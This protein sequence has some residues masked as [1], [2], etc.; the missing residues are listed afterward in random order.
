MDSLKI[1]I[2]ENGTVKIE[3]SAVSG[4]NHVNAEKALEWLTRELGGDVTRE[5]LA[6]VHSHTHEH[7]GISHTH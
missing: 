4:P 5:R 1:T 3:T 7:N 6:G 2:L